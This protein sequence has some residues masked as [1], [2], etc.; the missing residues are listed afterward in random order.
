MEQ[1]NEI[2]TYIRDILIQMMDTKLEI[3]PKKRFNTKFRIFL[4]NRKLIKTIINEG[5]VLVGSRALRCYSI[6]GKS[7]INRRLSDWD[8]IV[9]KDQ[10]IRIF[11]K[12]GIKWNLVDSVVSV[13]GQRVWVH[14][15]YSGS[16]QI[17]PVNVQ[18]II[19]DELPTY[20]VKDKIRFANISY[21]ISHKM[22]LADCK[23]SFHFAEK[24]TCQ[25][26]KHIDDLTQFIINF[27]S[28][29]KNE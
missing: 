17:G 18:I 28:E 6:N 8:F 12:T 10:A 1:I 27:Q 13:E 7:L 9:T 11:S 24:D 26:Q 23:C 20:N 19:E 21:I 14:T 5:G 2:K 4:P 29:I 25:Y 3:N 22:K 15:T 16:Y